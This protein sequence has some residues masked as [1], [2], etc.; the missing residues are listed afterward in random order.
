MKK[1]IIAFNLLCLF[2]LNSSCGSS[3][4]VVVKRPTRTVVVKKPARTVVVKTPRRVAVATPVRRT[5]V[6]RNPII[7]R[8]IPR[9]WVTVYYNSIP[10]YYVEGVYY[11]PTENKDEYIPVPPKTG[12][13][14]PSLP[15]GAV[16]KTIDDNIYYEDNDILY[17]EITVDGTTNYKVVS[18]P[19]Q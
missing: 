8:T 18:T 11:I 19:N 7:V 13:I 3:Q 14:V 16:K 5:V 4:T 1:N 6:Y 17:K 9:N 10:Y 2:L 15:K 12:T